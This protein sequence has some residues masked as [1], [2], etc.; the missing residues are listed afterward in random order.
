M[1]N[2]SGFQGIIC[3]AYSAIQRNLSLKTRSIFLVVLHLEIQSGQI[4]L[5]YGYPLLLPSI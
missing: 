3:S 2:F 4:A 5:R 1:F